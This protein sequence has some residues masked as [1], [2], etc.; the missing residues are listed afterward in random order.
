MRAILADAVAGWAPPP[1]ANPTS[2]M[3]AQPGL[4]VV[5]RSITTTPYSTDDS[6]LDNTIPAVP[7]LAAQPVPSDNPSFSSQIHAWT[8]QRTSWEQA[9]AAA[10]R[11]AAALAGQVRRFPIARN[12]WSGI[13]SCIAAVATQLAPAHGPGTRIAVLSDM[14]N[15]RPVTGLAL[16]GDAVLMV[17]ICPANVSTTCPQRFAAA[18][19]LLLQHG[20]SSVTIIRADAVTAGTFDAFWGAG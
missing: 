14:Q 15:N 16:D 6:S 9:A 3:K 11:A 2:T 19:S 10:A 17:T 8:Q 18:R 12:T 7:G 20:A 1:A 4:R 5:L 13:Y